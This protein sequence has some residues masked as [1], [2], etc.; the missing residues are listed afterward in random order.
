M[1]YLL[2]S[3]RFLFNLSAWQ[4]NIVLQDC[5]PNVFVLKTNLKIFMLIL[6]TWIYN[7]MFAL[8]VSKL[9]AYLNS[10]LVISSKFLYKSIPS[11]SGLDQ[12]ITNLSSHLQRWILCCLLFIGLCKASVQFSVISSQ[13][14]ESMRVEKC[15]FGSTSIF[16]IFKVYLNFFKI[17]G[18]EIFA[19]GGR[20]LNRKFNSML[21]KKHEKALWCGHTECCQVKWA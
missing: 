4:C 6:F 10:K 3:I 8:C 19:P 11:R 7:Y 13:N 9:I 1:L 20:A 14:P 17:W 18:L 21:E 16:C 15:N 5:K 2:G 12:I